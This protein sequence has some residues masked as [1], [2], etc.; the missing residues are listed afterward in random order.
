MQFK[1]IKTAL[2]AAK[3]DALQNGLKELTPADEF[4]LLQSSTV[5]QNVG[6][7]PE[8]RLHA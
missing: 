4:S 6:Y 7:R 2:E 3:N 1:D 5:G 8:F